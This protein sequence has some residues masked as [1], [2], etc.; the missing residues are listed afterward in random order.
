[1]PPTVVLPTT[2]T[3]VS[4][5]PPSTYASIE[6]TETSNSLARKAENLAVSK[7]P[8]IPTTFFLSKWLTSRAFCAIASRGLVTTRII[9][10]GDLGATSF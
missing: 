1:M 3:I 5:W 8:A 4:P 2:G 6:R 9:A 10:C 7:I